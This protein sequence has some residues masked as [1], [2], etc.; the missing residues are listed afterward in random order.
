ML[1]EQRQH[2]RGIR[3]D[4]IPH[5]RVEPVVDVGQHQIEIGLRPPKRL[6]FRRATPPA[7]R[8]PGRCGNRE[9]ACATPAS[10]RAPN[11]SI[12][13]NPARA[14]NS[15]RTSVVHGSEAGG[16]ADPFERFEVQLGQVDAI[17]VESGHQLLHPRRHRAEAVAVAARF[18]SLRQSSWASCSKPVFS[19]HSG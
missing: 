6:L 16:I 13:S 15:A 18:M 11:S 12:G 14:R 7:S 4:G 5:A 1:V 3:A 9:T 10:L 17:P 2:P 19:R 8:A